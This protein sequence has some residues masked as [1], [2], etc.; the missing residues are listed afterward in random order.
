VEDGVNRGVD[1][2]VDLVPDES[3]FRL[4]PVSPGN[5]L[6]RRRLE[7]TE[8]EPAEKPPQVVAIDVAKKF[9]CGGLSSPGRGAS[10]L[11]ISDR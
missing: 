6:A 2:R 5:L 4:T 9:H 10:S 11:I 7:Q 8:P 1:A 3:G